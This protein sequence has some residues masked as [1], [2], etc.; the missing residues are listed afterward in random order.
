MSHHDDCEVCSSDAMGRQDM[1]CE[2]MREF[3]SKAG[4]IRELPGDPWWSLP[5]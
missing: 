3:I 2:M 5:N 1:T 4:K